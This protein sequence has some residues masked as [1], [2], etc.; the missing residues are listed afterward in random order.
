M[1]LQVS[2]RLQSQVCVASDQMKEMLEVVDDLIKN[3]RG[4]KKVSIVGGACHVGGACS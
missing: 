3:K 2:E 4:A 1:F